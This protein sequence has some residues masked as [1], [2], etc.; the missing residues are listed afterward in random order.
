MFKFKRNHTK[1]T[2]VMVFILSSFVL[3]M[4]IIGQ[5]AGLEFSWQKSDSAN[6]AVVNSSETEEINIE[7]SYNLRDY[8]LEPIDPMMYEDELLAR[9]TRSFTEVNY[10][11]QEDP[12]IFE[13]D[14]EHDQGFNILNLDEFDQE[15]AELLLARDSIVQFSDV[16]YPLYISANRLN[17]RAGPTIFANVLSQLQFG[18]KVLCLG[19]SDDWL[20]ISVEDQTGYISSSFASREMV[21]RDVRETMY[22]SANKLNLRSAPDTA[23][24]VVIELSKGYTLTRTGIGD[25]WS[26]VRTA[27][28]KTGYVVTE[29]LTD[30][31]PIQYADPIPVQ[32]RTDSSAE[33]IALFTKIVALESSSRYGYEGYLAVASVI[34][35]RVDSSRFPN[36]ITRVV[37]QPG[38]FSVYTSTRKPYY[39]DNVRRAV[40]DALEGKRNLPQYV[41]FFAMPY[42]YERNVNRGGVFA[43]LDVYKTAYGHVWCYYPSDRR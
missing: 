10:S 8:N 36:S 41:L 25:G 12:K 43:K 3:A 11:L 16:E 9:S 22:V 30:K 40:K 15:T 24:D 4:P 13:P 2:S 26:R 19:E 6:A 33:E 28:G 1:I 5:Q 27:S 34:M 20:K 35:N 21:F 39:N 32:A 7:P 23:G 29:H 17:F 31:A 14:L 37:S 18:D 42:A 38:Q